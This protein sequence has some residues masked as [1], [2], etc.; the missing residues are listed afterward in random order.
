V[1][2]LEANAVQGE[3]E[4]RAQIADYEAT[5]EERQS[6]AK[7]RGEVALAEAGVDAG[8]GVTLLAGPGVDVELRTGMR[9]IRFETTADLQSKLEANWPKH[10]V[11]IMAAAV[12]DYRPRAVIDGKPARQTDGAITMTF[13]PT[14]DLVAQLAASKHNDQRIVAFALEEPQHL[15]SRAKEKLKR[16]GVDA[17]VANPLRTMEADQVE[18]MWIERSG[19]TESPGVMSKAAFANW[20]IERLPALCESK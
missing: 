11:L 13:E 16:K 19:N 7:R 12:A 6:E 15:E 5:L 18:A 1:A 9:V 8:Y 20:V 3:N 10:D 2:E 17:V 14:P 4:S